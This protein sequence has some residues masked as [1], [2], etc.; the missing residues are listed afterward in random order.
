MKLYTILLGLLWLSVTLRDLWSVA[1][2]THPLFVL[3]AIG[4]AVLFTLCLAGCLE[5][6][7]RRR[8]VRFSSVQWRMTYQATMAM[9]VFTVLLRHFGYLLGIADGQSAATLTAIGMDVLPFVLFAIPVILLEHER[10]S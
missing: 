3:R 6:A 5:L 9:G 8:L 7:W 10:N 2:A 1:F 4:T